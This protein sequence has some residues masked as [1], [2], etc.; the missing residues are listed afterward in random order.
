[1]HTPLSSTLRYLDADDVDDAVM[2]FDSAAVRSTDG[3]KVGVV[4]GFII[5]LARRRA[6]YVVVDSG[7]WFTSRHYLVPIGHTRVDTEKEALLL[8][9]G[10]DA[11]ARYP[12]FD[13]DRFAALN[14]DEL[15]GFE[16]QTVVACCPQETA[17]TD[18]WGYERW[19][20]YRQPEWWRTDVA[21]LQSRTRPV[22]RSAFARSDAAREAAV[23]VGT[24]GALG[25]ES[26]HAND[27]AQPGDVLGIE[28][29]GETTSLGDTSD[30]E[31]ERR[32]KSGP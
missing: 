4:D 27:R 18:A 31:N 25:D 10:K 20:H 7:G 32:R 21:G 29:A 15:R 11:I 30:D 17:A 2:D 16:S 3:E 24:A 8:D 5:D 13:P 14:D 12:E 26:P 28:T 19:A 22:A 1:M 9:I 23:P 6:Y